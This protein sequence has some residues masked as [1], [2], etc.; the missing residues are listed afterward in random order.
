MKDDINTITKMAKNLLEQLGFPEADVS[1]SQ[2][3]DDI[4]AVQINISPNDSGILIGFHGETIQALQTVLSQT[5]FKNKGEFQRVNVNIGDYREKR[6]LALET[7]ALNAA[8][9]AKTTNTQVNLPYL[10]SNER[11]IIHLKLS[12]DPDVETDSQGEG[13][14]RRLVIIPK[15]QKKDG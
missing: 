9:R 7:M 3:Q 8:D 14:E 6:E 13:R 10:S 4:F 1:V 15:T 11:R 2:D 12:Q 5:I